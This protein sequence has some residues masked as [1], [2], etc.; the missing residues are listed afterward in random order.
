MPLARAALPREERAAWVTGDNRVR[1]HPLPGSGGGCKAGRAGTSDVALGVLS[2]HRR[3]DAGQMAGA[4]SGRSAGH[5]ARRSASPPRVCA[6]RSDVRAASVAFCAEPRA[7]HP[8]SLGLLAIDSQSAKGTRWMRVFWKIPFVVRSRRAAAAYASPSRSNT[9]IAPARPPSPGSHSSGRQTPEIKVWA[10]PRSPE[11]PGRPRPRSPSSRSAPAIPGD[12]G[13]QRH[14]S[15]LCRCHQG[16]VCC[17]CVSSRGAHVQ[18]P[19]AHADGP[20]P[21]PV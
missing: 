8:Q 9:G 5:R 15:D 13:W 2:A 4:A 10:G 16:A 1:T 14:H 18:G 7:P 11:A 20:H 12:L 19:R 17:A 21:T 3:R 6:L